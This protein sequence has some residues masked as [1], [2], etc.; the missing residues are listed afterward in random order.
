LGIPDATANYALFH[1]ASPR[2]GQTVLVHGATGGVGV[3]AIQLAKRAG[4][5]VAATGGSETGRAMLKNSG[6]ILSSIIISL[7]TIR[8]FWNAQKTKGWTLF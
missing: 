7:A 4:L 6:L 2:R 1:R 8:T 3:A 5:R